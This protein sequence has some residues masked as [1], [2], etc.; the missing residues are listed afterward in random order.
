[1][2][3]PPKRLGIQRA[4]FCIEKHAARIPVARLRSSGNQDGREAFFLH[5]ALALRWRGRARPLC[6]TAGADIGLTAAGRATAAGGAL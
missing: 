6:A 4:Q 5:F 2:A 1:M 3:E